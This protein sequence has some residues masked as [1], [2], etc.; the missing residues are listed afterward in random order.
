MQSKWRTSFCSQCIVHFLWTAWVSSCF[1][2]GSWS[3]LVKFCWRVARQWVLNMMT[4]F[5]NGYW[6]M[7]HCVRSDGHHD[8]NAYHFSAGLQPLGN[9]TFHHLDT[10]SV[11]VV[12][13]SDSACSHRIIILVACSFRC[14]QWVE[15]WCNWAFDI[16]PKNSCNFLSSCTTESLSPL[17]KVS[18]VLK[19][20]CHQS[21]C[22]CSSL[23]W[24]FSIRSCACLIQ[25]KQTSVCFLC[26]NSLYRVQ[27]RM[28]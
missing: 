12:V 17:K 19:I 18:R 5:R 28:S 25:R 21:T 3:E 22:D 15:I 11:A 7:G 16:H 8:L 1:T 27:S 9:S 4:D 2:A 10:L 6:D 23:R 26:T 20:A 24:I 13:V 14:S